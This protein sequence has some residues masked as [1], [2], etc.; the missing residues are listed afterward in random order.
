MQN[1]LQ[2]IVCF[3][4][5]VSVELTPEAIRKSFLNLMLKID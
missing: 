3:L 4:N 1:V 5:R 2:V